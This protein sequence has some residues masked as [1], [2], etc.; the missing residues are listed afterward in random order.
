MI[1]K[2]NYRRA[3]IP[4]LPFTAYVLKKTFCEATQNEC[5]I[6]QPAH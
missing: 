3:K 5:L 1:T 2:K 6:N 4:Y